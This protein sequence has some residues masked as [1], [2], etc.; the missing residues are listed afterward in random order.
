[1]ATIIKL[2]VEIITASEG[3]SSAKVEVCDTQYY[4]NLDDFDQGIVM[5][6]EVLEENF[7]EGG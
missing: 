6:R 1:M 5:L 4:L 7:N 2:S 3:F